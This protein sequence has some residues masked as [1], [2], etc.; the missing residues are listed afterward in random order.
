MTA[1]NQSIGKP[2]GKLLRLTLVA[3]AA[4]TLSMLAGCAGSYVEG[5]YTGPYYGD[6]GPYDNAVFVTG[7]Y[8]GEHHFYGHSFGHGGYHGGGSHGGFHGGHGGRR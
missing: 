8:Y 7:G 4:L 3:A 1:P 5:P 6:Y 2:G